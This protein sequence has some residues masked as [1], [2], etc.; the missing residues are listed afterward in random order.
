MALYDDGKPVTTIGKAGIYK[1]AYHS[2]EHALVGYL[3]TANYYKN[4]IVLYY[5][6]KK[7]KKPENSKINPYYF[8]AEID[9]I[10]EYGFKDNSL[11]DLQCFKLS[12]NN[13]K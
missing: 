9:E 3:S 4:D 7:G 5:A 2:L 10:K 13:I 1:N 11:D 8:N 6:F 12:F